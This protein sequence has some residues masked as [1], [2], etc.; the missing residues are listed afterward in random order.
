MEK[1]AF[2][3]GATGFLGLNLTELLVGQGWQVT[4]LHR[5]ESNIEILKKIAPGVQLAQGSITNLPSVMQAIPQGVDAVFHVAG[6]TSQWKK[7]NAR[8]YE[9]NVTGTGN[10][11]QSALAKGAKKFIHTS[12]HSA[13][14]IHEGVVIDENTPSNALTCGSNYALTKYLSELEVLKGMEKGLETIILNP[15][16]IMGK[17]DTNNWAQLIIAVKNNKVPGIPPG[18]GMFCHVKD[19][20]QAHINAVN[21]GQN[22]HRYLLGGPNATFLQVFNLIQKKLGKPLSQKVTP[23]WA[24]RVA[25]FFMGMASAVTGKEP[26]LTPEKLSMLIR[27][28]VC[29]YQ[30]AMRELEFQTSAIETMIEDTLLTL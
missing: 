4:A 3:T 26:Q 8:Q 12:S 28:P 7:Y 23:A 2:I 13:F 22:G 1:T 10:V 24:L 11:V 19:V 20:A 5:P 30:K 17:Y 14:G 16:K 9:D 18:G 29:N 15:C 21:M 25:C 6:N 27:H